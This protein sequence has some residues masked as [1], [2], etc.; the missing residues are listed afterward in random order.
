MGQRGL[1]L[2]ALYKSPDAANDTLQQRGS[3]VGGFRALK[4]LHGLSLSE[5]GRRFHDGDGDQ[6]RE[7]ALEAG[8]TSHSSGSA[9]RYLL[10]I[11]RKSVAEG[12]PPAIDGLPSKEVR[13]ERV[14]AAVP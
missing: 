6:I 2:S 3:R 14:G 5:I 7:W 4:D 1:P 9:R 12:P 13:F 10:Q 11:Q 8:P